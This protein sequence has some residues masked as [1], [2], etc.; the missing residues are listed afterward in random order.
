MTSLPEH[1]LVCANHLNRETGLRCNR[2]EKPICAQCAVRTPTGYRCRECVRGQQKV[3]D[4]AKSQDYV[5]AASVGGILS[6]IG[7]VL[8]PIVFWFVI[9]LAPVAG[10]LI[11]EAIRYG[12]QRRRGKRLFQ[13]AAAAVAL[14]SLAPVC[15]NLLLGNLGFS[16]LWQ[17]IYMFLVTSTVY[18]RLSG[19]NL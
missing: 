4:T 15:G 8:A 16:L 3:F 19:I 17:G 2:C 6:F 10:G 12:I 18:Y 1:A 9:F 11:A 13:V 7:A 14:G 5:I